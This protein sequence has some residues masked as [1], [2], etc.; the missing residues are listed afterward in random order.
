MGCARSAALV[1]ADGYER[2]TGIGKEAGGAVLDK[3]L[4]FQLV[5]GRPWRLV[6]LGIRVAS[7]YLE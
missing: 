1:W 6:V 7:C 5:P 2:G 3:G 4:P